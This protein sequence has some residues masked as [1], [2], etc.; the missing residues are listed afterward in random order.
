MNEIRQSAGK[1]LAWLCGFI[2]GDG[3]ITL[4]KQR[5]GNNRIIYTPILS[6]TNTDHKLIEE[7]AKVLKEIEVGH[8]FTTRKTKNGI[9]K[10]LVVKGFKRMKRLLPFIIQYLKGSKLE[11]AELLLEWI[12]SREKTGNN[13][14]YTEYE[15]ALH[16]EI[17]NLK[18]PDYPQRLHAK[19][20]NG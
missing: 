15:L 7:S 12:E 16:K 10:Q 11:Q 14:T 2:N 5:M 18:K 13:N 4:S 6:I 19:P 8:Y 20:L 1:N 3:S 17:I 9:A